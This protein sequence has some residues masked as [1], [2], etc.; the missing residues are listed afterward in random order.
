MVPDMPPEKNGN[1]PAEGNKAQIIKNAAV[2]VLDEVTMMS[3]INLERIDRT[4][5]DI[6][7]KKQLLFGGKILILSG[8]F[9]QILPIERNPVDSINTCLKQ[10]KNWDQI[11][12]LPLTINE[13]L[14]RSM[15]GNKE[16][17]EE[18]E[19][20]L[21]ALGVGLIQSDIPLPAHL[22]NLKDY[23][24]D[25]ISLQ[26]PWCKQYTNINEFLSS[27]FPDIETDFNIPITTVLTPKNCDLYD[28]NSLCINKF[29]PD[30]AP[31]IIKSLDEPIVEEYA[32]IYTDV[33]RTMAEEHL[34]KYNP[35]TL[36]Q[37]ILELKPYCPLMILRNIDLYNGI[38]NGTRVQLLQIH[39]KCLQVKL[40]NGPFKDN[41]RFLC[42]I[43]NTNKNDRNIKMIRRQFP[44]RLCYGMT[45]HKAQ[46]QTIERLGI[47]LP[48]PVFTHGQLY[49][50]LS[51]VSDPTQ[52][53]VYI[54]DK[55]ETQYVD[56]EKNIFY[57]KNIVFQQILEEEIILT[58]K[59][60]NL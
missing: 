37:H 11:K 16:L 50:A 1:I 7:G 52:I 23:T 36:P 20:F 2:L 58:K 40:L 21:L 56:R 39:Q 47:Y 55:E 22:K 3:K 4:L 6:T 12:K 33:T 5:R 41:I 48:N 35:G 10:W 18:Y 28:I 9:R 59:R 60:L 24:E 29:R 49:V 17:K 57:T 46:G 13:R 38:A 14:R 32:K 27:M 26:Y 19:K 25:F 42:K 54:D 44:I 30:I 15:S 34:N 51:R 8:D 43:P 45:I 53:S 31:T